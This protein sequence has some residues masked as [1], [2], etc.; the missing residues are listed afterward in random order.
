M[1]RSESIAKRDENNDINALV[2]N[3]REDRIDIVLKDYR[4]DQANP[5]VLGRR[6][7]EHY[8]RLIVDIK[9][10]RAANRG[11]TAPA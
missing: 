5:N 2:E 6:H 8:K 10:R 1:E 7:M 9:S 11:S 4:N 3:S